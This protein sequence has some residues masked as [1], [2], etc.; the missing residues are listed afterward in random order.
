MQNNQTTWT[1]Q[2]SGALNDMPEQWAAGSNNWPVVYY[3]V[4]IDLKIFFLLIIENK[5][6]FS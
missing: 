1:G 5:K 2:G 6:P 3:S 4:R